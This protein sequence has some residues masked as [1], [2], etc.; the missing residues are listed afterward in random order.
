MAIKKVAVIGATGMLG[1]PVTREL[2]RAGFEVSILVRNVEKAQKIFSAG[3][4]TI[5]GSLEDI[6]SIKEWMEGQDALYLNLS[7]DQNSS[8]NYFQPEREGLENLLAAARS[9]PQMRIGY[10]SSLVQFYQGRNGF[11]WWVFALKQEALAKIKNSGHP[12]SVFY[13]ST[14]MEN[15]DKGAYVQG[16]KI[17]LAGRSVHPM[18]FISGKDYGRQV[19]KA[20]QQDQGNRE[21]V[22]QGPEAYTADEAARIYAANYASPKLSLL[23]MPLGLLYFLGNFSKKL[24]YGAHIIDALNNYP[25]KFEAGKTWEELG[26]PETT[27]TDYIREVNSEKLKVKS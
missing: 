11:H 1:Q 23:K 5:K 25:E 20:F 27:F 10:L 17:L 24:N 15:F 9:F 19:V 13:P 22:I 6:G 4:R 3:V 21:Y 12:Y 18:F 2:L 8:E 14:F 7:V 16:N 26:R